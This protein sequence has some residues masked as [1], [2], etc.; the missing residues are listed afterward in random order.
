MKALS[1]GAS[2]RLG[3]RDSTLA[4]GYFG[5]GSGVINS[6]GRGYGLCGFEPPRK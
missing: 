4:V 1:L 6:L 2:G 3:L 5:L